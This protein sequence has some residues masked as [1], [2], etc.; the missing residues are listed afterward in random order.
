MFY[1]QRNMRTQLE[2]DYFGNPA[3]GTISMFPTSGTL[4]DDVITLNP[5]TVL[6]IRLNWTLYGTS[7]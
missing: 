3:T 6:D 4:L 5:T 7:A 2:N 1:F